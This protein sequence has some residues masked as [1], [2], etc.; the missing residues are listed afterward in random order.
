MLLPTSSNKLAAQWQGPYKVERR[1]GKVNYVVDMHDRRKRRRI[2]H[3]SML[4]E[5]H[6]GSG[7]SAVL[8]TEGG[9]E[10]T[11]ISQC[12]GIT[13]KEVWRLRSRLATS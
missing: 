3:I 2:F 5:F 6:S 1:V 11:D 12:G 10:E 4:R 7:P 13:K 8:W 9:E